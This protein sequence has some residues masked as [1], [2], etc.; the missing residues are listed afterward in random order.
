MN[1]PDTTHTTGL[2]LEV[3]VAI[4]VR[5]SVNNKPILL[6]KV[7]IDTGCTRTRSSL[8]DQFFETGKRLNEVSWTTNTGKLVTKYKIP[9]QFLLPEFAPSREI[10]WNV[11]VDETAQQS[12]YDMIIERDLQ[13]AIRMDI[14]FSTKHLKWDSIV[15]PMRTQ[16]IDLSYIDN[17]VK[18]LGNSQDV[19][20]TASTPMSI[21]DAKYEKANIDATI[22]S[23]KHLSNN[24]QQQLKALLYKFEHLFDGTLGNWKTDPLSFKL[25][26]GAKPFQLAPFSVSKIHE[27]TLKREI[28]SLCDLGVLKPQVASEYLSPSFIIPKKNGTVRVVSDFRVL[29]S[30]LQRVAFPIPKIQDILTSLNGFTFASSIDL[31]MGYY[32]I[33]L[34]PQAQ[35]LF[36]I[37]F[38]WGKYSYLRLPMGVANSPDIFQ[39]KIS[40][41]MVGLDFVRAYLDDVLVATKGSYQEH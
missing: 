24:Q 37:V 4:T 15:M 35:K 38:P 19:F 33:C 10:N 3:S 26:E 36:T 32:T 17:C 30:K 29:D 6:N 40:Q 22:N 14:L 34:K 20:A 12:K 9:L 5:S 39:S 18:N 27:T 31:N 1:I 16:N 28:Q 25:K 2:M 41:L 21:L 11:A 8:P 23:L 7:L 13:I